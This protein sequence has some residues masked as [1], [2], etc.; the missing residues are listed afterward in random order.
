MV[1]PSPTGR[2]R[3]G[4]AEKIAELS[5]YVVDDSAVVSVPGRMRF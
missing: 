2:M 3:Q 5:H 1:R 4:P